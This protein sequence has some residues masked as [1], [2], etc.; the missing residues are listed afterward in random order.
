MTRT[1]VPPALP[2]VACLLLAGLWGMS[3]FD[4]WVQNAFCSGASSSLECG[5]RLALV[6]TVS[7]G[8]AL[9]AGMTTAAGWIGR[10]DDLLGVA[11][12]AWLVAVGVLFVGGIAVQ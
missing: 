7:A 10:R 8:V 11:V 5:D 6:S 3:T 1:W 9:F 2:M 4:G 12:A